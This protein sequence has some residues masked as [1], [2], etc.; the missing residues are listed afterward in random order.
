MKMSRIRNTGFLYKE[1][2][3]KNARSLS[4]SIYLSISKRKAHLLHELLLGVGHAGREH[5][6]HVHLGLVKPGRLQPRVGKN[7]GFLGF[8][9]FVLG[10]WGFLGFFFVFFIIC[11]LKIRFKEKSLYRVLF[12]IFI[13][14]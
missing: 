9:W 4:L 7:P 2:I 11:S 12:S 5:G 1:I 6:L 14:N 10:F 8:F 3:S 13:K